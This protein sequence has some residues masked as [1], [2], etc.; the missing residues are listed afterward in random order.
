[1]N[2]HNFG[3]ILVN[4]NPT[5]KVRIL[6]TFSLLTS[7]FR[8]TLLWL[9]ACLLLIYAGDIGRGFIADDFGWIYFSRI[10]SAADAWTLLVEGAPGFY[11]P[12][13]ALSFGV[14]ERLFG[15][16]PMAFAVTNLCMAC[17][18]MMGIVLLA[19]RLGFPAVGGV[20]AAA[21][22]SLN[23]H[24]IGMALMW[25]SG[26]TSLLATLFAVF[27]AV[28]FVT[29]RSVVAGWLTFGALLSK[30]EPVLLPVI[31]A[32]WRWVDART[33]NQAAARR[34][35]AILR[36]TWP[37]FAALAAYAVLR[38]RTEAFTPATA[39]SFYRLS[40]A[41]DVIVPNALQYLDRSLTF[42]AAVLLLGIVA[43]SRRWPRM[44]PL[45]WRTCVKGFVWLALGFAVTIML[46]VRSSLYVVF[47]TIGSALI[48]LAAGSAVWR[49]VPDRRRRSAIV[50]LCALPLLLWPIHYLRHQPTKEQAM[51]STRVVARI[52]TGLAARPDAQRV[53]VYD[54]PLAR[55]TV[56]SAFGGALAQ[57]VELATGRAVPV[58]VT[59][60]GSERSVP[61]AGPP[62]G[63]LEF[64]LQNGDLVPLDR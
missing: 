55:P 38:S 9:F 56:V 24:G 31:F 44:T 45:E 54:D 61:Q 63:T 1:M 62:S 64:R 20:F 13:V 21:L 49:S 33:E 46:P 14:N 26:R 42:T 29:G 43:F 30:E 23:F 47:P 22:W 60:L 35:P 36:A 32:L 25:V 52:R 58:E 7:N 19:T 12:L 2:S 27:G 34:I 39:P 6:L 10:R 37:S 3:R 48:G 5:W 41:P 53:V 40:A 15:L 18:I 4:G 11:R 51:L 50:A 8:L 28:A 17:A 16:S 57:A 59:P